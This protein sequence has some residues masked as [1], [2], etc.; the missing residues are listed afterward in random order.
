MNIWC[1]VLKYDLKKIGKICSEI[2]FI[3]KD[4]DLGWI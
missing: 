1:R 4:R 2:K 3:V